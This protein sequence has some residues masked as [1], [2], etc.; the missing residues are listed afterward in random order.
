MRHISD[1][2]AVFI[3][4]NIKA[5]LS[6]SMSAVVSLP[7]LCASNG[8]SIE[9]LSRSLCVFDF[10]ASRQLQMFTNTCPSLGVYT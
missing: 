4:I 3:L 10:A 1:H 9:F 8:K 7:A 6:L 5:V 2:D